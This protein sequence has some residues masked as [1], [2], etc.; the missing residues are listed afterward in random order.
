MKTQWRVGVGRSKRSLMNLDARATRSLLSAM[1]LAGAI[2]SCSSPGTDAPGDAADAGPQTVTSGAGADASGASTGSTGDASTPPP[3]LDGGTDAPSDPGDSSPAAG[4]GSRQLPIPPRNQWP[5]GDGYCGEMSIQSIALYYGAWISEEVARTVA[6]GELLLGSNATKALAALHVDHV[7]WDSSAPKPQFQSFVSWMK[8]Y[9]ASGV[10]CIYAIYLTDGNDDPDYDHIVPAVG[11]TYGDLSTY[12]ASDTLTS[13]DNFDDQL[14]RAF[15]T[16][17]GTRAS[18]A[19]SS[20]QGGCIPQDV[21]YGVAFLGFLDAQHV[22]LPVSIKVPGDSEPNTSL[23]ASP[24]ALTATVS[25]SGLQSGA[26]YSLLRY[27]DYTKVPEDASAAGFLASSY[28]SRVDFTATGATWDYADPK[29]FPSN[30]AVYYR[31]V[32][33]N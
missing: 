16:L 27:D 32:R 28:T 2:A 1:G 15:G 10:P 6:G 12:A 18:C 5:D 11:V 14:T 33:T 21:D 24:S 30:G 20:T 22:T 4:P 8:G 23:G 26:H 17:S 25:V 29:T 19:Y 3:A 31:C 9:V 13:N 7:D